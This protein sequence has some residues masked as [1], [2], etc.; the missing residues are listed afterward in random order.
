MR[1]YQVMRPYLRKLVDIGS[2]M[3]PDELHFDP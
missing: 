1:S 3:A 2:W